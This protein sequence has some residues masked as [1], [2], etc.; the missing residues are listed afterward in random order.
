VD[1]KICEHCGREFTK[2]PHLSRPNWPK[3]RFCTAVCFHAAIANPA[4]CPICGTIFKRQ[5]GQQV[6]CKARE[7]ITRYRVEVA[8][9]AAS[10]RM[11]ED[12]AAGKRKRAAGISP[13]ELAL[14]PALGA[15]G[16]VWRLR[17]IELA[18]EFELDFSLPDRKLNVEIDG[19]EHRWVK[20]RTL[21]DARDA[22]LGA[23]GWRILRIPNEDVD[24]DPG[25]VVERIVAWAAGAD[26]PP[27]MPSA[28][29]YV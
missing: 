17:W 18:M 13:R 2:P 7:C 8:G 12:Y 14:W 9:P 5:S 3:R 20:R 16:W 11:R 1:V 28:R 24:T 4:E 25:A 21:D 19:P 6:T 23:R 26:S 10:V 15:L 29:E 22:E 27:L